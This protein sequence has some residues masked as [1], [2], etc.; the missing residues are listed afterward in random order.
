VITEALRVLLLGV[1]GVF[2]V[3]ALIYV[4]IVVLSRIR[5]PSS[6]GATESNLMDLPAPAPE[7][8]GDFREAGTAEP[9]GDDGIAV[10]NTAAADEWYE[11]HGYDGET[12]EYVYEFSDPD[13][14]FDGGDMYEYVVEEYYP[15]YE[16]IDGDEYTDTE[17]SRSSQIEEV[18]Q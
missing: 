9:I 7:Q 2:L 16:F 3:M 17:E 10:E 18:K 8:S 4:V 11:H 1:I 5:M 14:E 15:D 12:I 6:A 13:G